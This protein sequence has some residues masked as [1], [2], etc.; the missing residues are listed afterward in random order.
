MNREIIHIAD[1]PWSNGKTQKKYGTDNSSHYFIAETWRLNMIVYQISIILARKNLKPL[2]NTY[3][4]G[5]IVTRFF[6]RIDITKGQ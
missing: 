1:H 3:M 5:L 6:T 4:G 2:T